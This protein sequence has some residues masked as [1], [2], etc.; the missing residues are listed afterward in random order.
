MDGWMDYMRRPDDGPPAGGISAT[1]VG[2]LYLLMLLFVILEMPLLQ[3]RWRF[4][5]SQSRARLSRR[6]YVI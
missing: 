2:Y 3:G 1:R 6:V 5:S 4:V